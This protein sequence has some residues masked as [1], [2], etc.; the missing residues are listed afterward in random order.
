[1]KKR[2][3]A[4][5]AI[6][7]LSLSLFAACKKDNNSGGDNSG[8]TPE[9]PPAI[10]TVTV[11]FDSNGGTTVA[12]M[13]VNKGDKITEPEVKST[14]STLEVPLVFDGWYLGDEKWDFS[15]GVSA[16]MTLVAKWKEDGRYSEP[17][18]PKA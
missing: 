8:T 16:D 10:V 15:D 12:P 4:L 1:M 2:F 5:I 3:L 18:I 17:V 11:T 9:N 7:V 14:N 6:L 13:T